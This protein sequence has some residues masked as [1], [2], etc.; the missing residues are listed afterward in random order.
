MVGWHA[1]KRRI[2]NSDA[3]WISVYQML[4]KRYPANLVAHGSA[5]SGVQRYFSRYFSENKHLFP[6]VA[7]SDAMGP[8]D[9]SYMDKQIEK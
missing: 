8:N 5:S 1:V 4:K 7:V 6:T 3:F 2:D 9:D